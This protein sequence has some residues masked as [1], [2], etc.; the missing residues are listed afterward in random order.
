MHRGSPG[1]RRPAGRS[2]SSRPTPSAAEDG[3]DDRGPEAGARHHGG[4]G[5]TAGF[6]VLYLL[7]TIDMRGPGAVV[8]ALA[9][10]LS[11]YSLHYAA[12][13]SVILLPWAGLGWML[14]LM[15]R[16]LRKGGW[17]YPAAFAIVVQIVGSVNAT[18]LVFAL[19]APLL[20]VPYA[21]WI[22][23]E[24][25]WR[26]AALTL[27][28]I[29]VLTLGASL[30]WISGLWAQGAYGIDILK[31]TETVKTVA[32]AGVAPEVPRGLG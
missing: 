27:A 18:A 22:T 26:R 16:A 19:V 5:G 28:R 1:R 31:Y 9:Y 11:P 12:R 23:R 4:A 6:G 20:W 17:R 25:D 3:R 13:I 32:T 29:G 21:V 24:V 2:K 15:V 10:M 7:R 8:A 14:A 30:W